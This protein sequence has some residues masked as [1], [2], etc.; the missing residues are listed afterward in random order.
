MI[1]IEQSQAAQPPFMPV[2]YLLLA[3]HKLIQL[4]S[5]P[6]IVKRLQ[7]ALDIVD[8]ITV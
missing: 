5:R 6:V 8:S 3:N 1:T 2:P 4:R 7:A